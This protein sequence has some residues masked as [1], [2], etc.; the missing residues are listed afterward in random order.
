MLLLRRH[1]SRGWQRKDRL[2]PCARQ[3]SFGVRLI[4]YLPAMS[5]I[6]GHANG[7]PSE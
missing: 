4:D 7:I 3:F 6:D 2:A 5:Y 1:Q